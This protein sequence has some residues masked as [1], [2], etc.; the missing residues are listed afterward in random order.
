MRGAV[1]CLTGNRKDAQTMG[2]TQDIRAA[3]EDELVFDPLVDSSSIR[4]G[5]MDGEVALNGTVSNFPQYREAEAASRRVA[6]V[7]GVH[8]HLQVTLPSWDFRNDSVLTISAINKLDL[9]LTVPGTVEAYARNGTVVLTGTVRYG[10]Q[11]SAAEDAVATL[12]G[13]RGVRDD[14]EITWDADPIDVT[15]AVKDA[16]DRYALIP[17]DSDVVVDT[18]GNAVTLSGH[19]RSWAEHDA[20][21]DA[22]WKTPAVYD[23]FDRLVVTG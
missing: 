23:V 14:I 3:V 6:G 13:V 18:T 15:V 20:M 8:N 9:D 11:R 4:V 10:Y 12:T 16:L 5:S 22:A 19:V 1:R 7:T 17:D 21:L 2:K